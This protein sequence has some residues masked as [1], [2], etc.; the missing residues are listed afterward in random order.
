MFIGGKKK[1]QLVEEFNVQL[2]SN[3]RIEWDNLDAF[4]EKKA[5]NRDGLTALLNERLG[6]EAPEARSLVV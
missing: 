4:I 5:V 6:R 1:E 2:Y 3:G